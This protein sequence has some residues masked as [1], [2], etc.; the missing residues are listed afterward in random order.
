[1]R[2]QASFASKPNMKLV[3]RPIVLEPESAKS[4]PLR[5][6]SFIIK[7]TF[8]QSQWTDQP[9]TRRTRLLGAA[10]NTLLLNISLLTDPV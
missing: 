8:S 10:K 4:L 6:T 3:F 5:K 7:V 1:M 2:R 9:T